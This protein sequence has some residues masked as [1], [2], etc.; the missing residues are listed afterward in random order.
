MGSLT[1]ILAVAGLAMLSAG[2]LA[3]G[4]LFG[5]IQQENTAERRLEFRSGQA[6]LGRGRRRARSVLDATRRRKCVQDTLKELEA[7]QKEKAKH[8][9]SPSMTARMQQAGLSWSRRTFSVHQP[10]LRRF[11]LPRGLHPRRAAA[12]RRRFRRRRRPR[13]AALDREFPA[14]APPQ[15]VRRG[16]RQRRRR[17]R[18]RRQGRP[19]AER[20]HPASSPTR[21][22]SR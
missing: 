5:R 22:P 21:R 14:Q 20:L 10:R 4:L 18:A 2:G 15:Q 8:A 17:H 12:R 6:R 11:H 13:P 19:A 3:Y 16:V 1:L 9:K 7:R